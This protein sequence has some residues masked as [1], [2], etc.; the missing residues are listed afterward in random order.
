[1]GFVKNGPTMNPCPQNRSGSRGGTCETEASGV[2]DA[3]QR[4][5]EALLI[6]SLWL[7]TMLAL[8]PV[9]D[10]LGGM[11]ERLPLVGAAIQTGVRAALES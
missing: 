11:G 10:W 3:G 1:M 5:A 4:R 8:K 7:L 2:R 9:L 6:W